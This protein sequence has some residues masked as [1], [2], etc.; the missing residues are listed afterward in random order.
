MSNIAGTLS[1]LAALWSK[2]GFAI[3]VLR[4][5][6]G[7]QKWFIWFMIL[8][9]NLVMGAAALTEWISCTPLEKCY[10]PWI[11]GTCWDKAMIRHFFQFTAGE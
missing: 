9:L 8:S 4:I 1:I 6:N 3:M 11:K 2:T 10:H 5:A 7:W